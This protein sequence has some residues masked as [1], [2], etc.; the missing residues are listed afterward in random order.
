[1]MDIKILDLDLIPY[2]KAWEIQ[3]NFRQ[4]R[5][6]EEI[7]DHL[8]LV[9]HPPVF[10]I[11]KKDCDEDFCSS[12]SEIIADGIEIVKTNRGGRITYHGPGQLVGYFICKLNG[13]GVKEFV[14]NIEEV[15]IKTL[16]NFDIK[17]HRDNEH[18]GVWI[19][20]NKIA[21]I[22]LHVTHGVTMHGFALNVNCDL[23]PYRH[24][25]AC[26]IRDCGVT[27]M[28]ESKNGSVDM[29]DVKKTLCATVK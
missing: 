27:S 7:P 20:K 17:S 8:L 4:K 21:A 28:A 13:L 1:M 3:E 29:R 6:A 10:T 26:G 24:I 5:I 2:I 11:G 25:I 19:G 15:C 22:G 16:S 12:K 23:A 9:E 14:H 18:P